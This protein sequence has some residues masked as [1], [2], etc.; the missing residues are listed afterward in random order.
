MHALS[1]NR[2]DITIIDFGA[3]FGK[4][5]QLQGQIHISPPATT[6]V[7]SFDVI[8]NLL[9]FV[10]PSFIVMCKSS[11]CN[12][13]REFRIT[14]SFVLKVFKLGWQQF[15]GRDIDFLKQS[16]SFCVNRLARL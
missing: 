5:G 11:S 8:W 16:A 3:D 1:K 6:H 12:S 15:K 2:G 13:S 7:K 9:G 4:V 14:E 10:L